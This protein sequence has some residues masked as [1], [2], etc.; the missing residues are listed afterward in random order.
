MLRAVSAE[1]DDTTRL[2]THLLLQILPTAAE[3]DLNRAQRDD[4]CQPAGSITSPENAA[5]PQTLLED[6]E[7]AGCQLWDITISEEP[8]RI[9]VQHAALVI[10]PQV[11]DE[12]LR[13]GQTRMAELLIG[14]MANIMCHCTM[15]D[16][17]SCSVIAGK[18]EQFLPPSLIAYCAC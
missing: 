8:A 18:Q 10:L 11:A 16:Q 4:H 2:V 7:Q 14:S 15:A 13:Q 5:T 9:A 17:V 1:I 3:N 12:A 6:R